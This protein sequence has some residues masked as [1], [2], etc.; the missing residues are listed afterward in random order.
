MIQNPKH[1]RYHIPGNVPSRLMIFCFHAFRGDVHSALCGEPVNFGPVHL[2]SVDIS[3]LLSIMIIV[4]HF[5][6]LI[7]NRIVNYSGV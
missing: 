1:D 3:P 4:K 2:L 6:F 7:V 5:H